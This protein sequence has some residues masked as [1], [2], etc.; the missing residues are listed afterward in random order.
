[1]VVL[2]MLAVLGLGAGLGLGYLLMSPSYSTMLAT[3]VGVAF[4]LLAVLVDLE[5][6]M[7]LWLVVSP[8]A[9]F[10][11]LDI[12]LGQ[13]IPDLKLNRL[14]TLVLLAL[15]AAQV[16]IGRRKVA[17]VYWSD[18]FFVL[19]TLFT[20][21]S[22]AGAP[23]STTAMLQTFWDGWLVPALVYILARQIFSTEQD[24]KRIGITL[25][26]IGVYL[27]LLATHEQLTGIVLFYPENRSIVYTANVRRV[28][29]LLGNPALTAACLSV[30]A[31]FAA[32]GM[33]ESRTSG[34]RLVWLGVL[35]VMAVG[36]FMC[37][38]RAGWAAFVLG[39]LVMI[40]FYPRFRKV[41]LPVFL[42]AAV[43]LAATWGIVSTTP[44]IEERLQAKGPIEYRLDAYSVLVKMIKA[45]PI[46]GVGQGNYAKYYNLYA[47]G[48]AYQYFDPSNPRV[49][50]S[51]HNSF[52]Y[53]L[54]H[55]GLLTF[56]S[57]LG[58]LLS[59][60]WI[61]V[62]FYRESEEDSTG[63]VHSLIVAT[64]G[65]FVGY[66][67]P[68]MAADIVAFPYTT[69]LFFVVIGGVQGWI[70]G[71]GQKYVSQETSP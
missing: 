62:R 70:F 11:P 52:M 26:I 27:G 17:R 64:W 1:M 6:G 60:F 44:A 24:V 29:N 41:F 61:T 10:I 36:T 54:V 67:V 7:L 56:L 65:A 50:A 59:S 58:F 22:Y 2:T 49:V 42:I 21:M 34:R 37:Y 13:G 63:R 28:V 30:A 69:M 20:L 51:P 8:Y 43:V 66:L 39:L 45:N 53:V 3:V 19:F 38:N 12:S 9:R 48:V 23:M 57:Y 15:W 40:P 4:C 35:V 68:S 16:A 31:P 18:V 71:E 5:M 55:G 25:G 32:R 33:V 46:T 47:Y 14:V